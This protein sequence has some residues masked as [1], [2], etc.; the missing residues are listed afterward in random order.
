M[1]TTINSYSDDFEAALHPLYAPI[2]SNISEGRVRIG[3]FVVTLASQA[4]GED[5]ALVKIPKGARILGGEIAASAT[6]AN[7][8]Q[9][10]VGLMG[11]DL[12]GFI[13]DTVG[14]TVADSVTFLKAA[15]V[16]G[17]TKVGFALTTALG[18]MYETKKEV[19]LT[20]TTS[21][22]TVATEVVK[23]HVLYVV[24]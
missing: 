1:A 15:A 19:I 3:G 13:D 7:S 10:S 12:N 14:A 24:D 18:Y 17:A 22:G 23:G 5:I 21:V 6:L 16:Q 8:A 20:I 2:K 9:I 11:A 4:A